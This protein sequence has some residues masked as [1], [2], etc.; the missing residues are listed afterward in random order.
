MHIEKK[1]PKEYKREERERKMNT[2]RSVQKLRRE[3]ESAKG[4]RRGDK[5]KEER[6]RGCER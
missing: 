2:K 4:Q 1:L 6:K 3:R 5:K